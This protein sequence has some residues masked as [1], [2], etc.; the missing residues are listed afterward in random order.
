[1][2]LPNILTTLRLLIIPVFGVVLFGRNYPIATLLFFI[3][4]AT[5]VLDGYIARKRDIVTDWGKIADPVAD[6]LMQVTAAVILAIIGRIPWLFPII[7]IVKEAGMLIGTIF[8]LKNQKYVVSSK[9]Y[10][11]MATVVF[12][13]SIA[14]FILC[15]TSK[16]ASIKISLAVILVVLFAFIKYCID[17]SRIRKQ[18]G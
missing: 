13:L 1:M 11:K 14:F 8:L 2:N 4:C 9:W 3:A 17:F 10:G 16:A 6:K 12:N 18:E 15:E 5:D 7:I